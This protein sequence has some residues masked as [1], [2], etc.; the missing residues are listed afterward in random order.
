MF[1]MIVF[2]FLTPEVQASNEPGADER[3]KVMVKGFAQVRR[4][5]CA[6]EVRSPDRI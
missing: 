5:T 2:V 1:W 4:P 6:Y 3:K